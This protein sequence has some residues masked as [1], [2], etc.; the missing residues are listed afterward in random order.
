MYV[1]W[2]L[3]FYVPPLV[4]YNKDTPSTQQ[5]S[6]IFGWLNKHEQKLEIFFNFVYYLPSILFKIKTHDI[7]L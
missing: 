2:S 6:G 1:K 7:N 3:A 5:T 4:K